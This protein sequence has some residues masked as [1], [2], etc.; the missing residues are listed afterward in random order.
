VIYSSV[1]DCIGCTPLVSLRR[2]FPA[3]LPE[4]IAKL[5]LLNPGGSVKDRG[6]RF[7]I[8]HGLRTGTITPA[9]HLLESSSGN[10]GIALAM[11]ARIY[12]LT[13]TCVVDPK[14]SPTNLKIL[15]LLGANIEMV[16]ERDDQ[17]G[18]LQTRIHRV[19]ELLDILPESQWINQYA[20]QLNWQTHFMDTG[21]EILAALDAPV[22]YLVMAVSTVGTLLGIARR[23]R[24]SYPQLQVIAVDAAGS[25]IFGAPS[26]P[27]E[28]PGIG[29]SRVPELLNKSEIND[30]IYVD[31]AESAR[32]CR[33][34]LRTEGIFAGGSSGSIVAALQK[35]LPTL[36]ST[37]RVLTL[38]P[39]RGERY[40][41]TVYD[42]EW[43]SHLPIST[44]T[45]PT[46]ESRYVLTQKEL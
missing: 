25:V 46:N 11:T 19:Q 6:A 8:E 21:K 30:V 16:H 34:L 1:V 7:I 39:D 32:G 29:A 38:F 15:R 14:I 17:G 31:D 10:F 20:N 37:A 35:L 33:A 40:L 45:L 27:R 36:P 24:T 26:G 3:P 43:V 5:E 12:N 41:D 4:T 42:D 2:L 22:D 18:Y 44:T 13:F 23:L 28:I 9:T